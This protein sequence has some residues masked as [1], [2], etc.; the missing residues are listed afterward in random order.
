M[1]VFMCAA[2][3]ATLR[4]CM[5]PSTPETGSEAMSS[6]IHWLFQASISTA[7]SVPAEMRSTR[8]SPQPFSRISSGAVMPRAVSNPRTAVAPRAGLPGSPPAAPRVRNSC[9][10]IKIGRAHV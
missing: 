5:V 4:R 10:V 8:D 2:P 1:P 9:C 7:A 3:D 6:G